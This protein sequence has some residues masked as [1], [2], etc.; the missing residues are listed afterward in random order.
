LDSIVRGLVFALPYRYAR[1]ASDEINKPN[2]NE[3][4]DDATANCGSYLGNVSF[5]PCPEFLAPK[6]PEKPC[7]AARA[8]DR[9]G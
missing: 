7:G 9:A 8:P 4:A 3:Q 5:L 6:C 2:N 1:E